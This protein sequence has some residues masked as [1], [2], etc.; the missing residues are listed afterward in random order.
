[1]VIVNTCGTDWGFQQWA[2]IPVVKAGIYKYLL[3]GEYY[4]Y[5]CLEAGVYKQVFTNTCA[6]KQVL[7]VGF[8]KYLNHEYVS[9]PE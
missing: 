4:E 1:V 3:R 7:R 6:Y 8:Y 9:A 2:D 5:Q